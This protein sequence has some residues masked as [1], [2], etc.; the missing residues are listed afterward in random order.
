MFKPTPFALGAITI[1]AGLAAAGFTTD[2]AG[3]RAESALEFSV[4]QQRIRSGQREVY[5][6]REP[7]RVQ[8]QGGGFFRQLF[9]FEDYREPAAPST[10]AA[11]DLK[12]AVCRRT[13]DG[14]QLVLGFVS[15]REDQKDA[16]AMCAVA[17]AGE[18]TSFELEKFMPAEAPQIASAGPVLMEGRAS[19]SS[20][21]SARP[22]RGGC[23][24]IDQPMAVPIL[25]DTT[26]RRGDVVATS[27]G[28]KVFVGKG[29]PPFRQSDFIALDQRK[30][31]SKDLR[32]VKIAD[33]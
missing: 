25:H 21:T 9:G 13:C 22:V 28:F 18:A 15:S 24:K 11:P 4:N 5:Y 26:L 14:A 7:R 31:I 16:R 20:E 10:A 30:K 12:R 6:S 27:G 33:R 17:G 3:V 8:P 29:R 1:F 2:R 32:G 23:A 19:L